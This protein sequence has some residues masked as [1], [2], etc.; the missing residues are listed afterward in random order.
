MNELKH[1]MKPHR[2]QQ[3]IVIQI[4]YNLTGYRGAAGP[5]L[6]GVTV[7]WSLSKTH[8]Y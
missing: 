5:S 4:P 6:T 2:N 7:L 1:M 3:P 8:L